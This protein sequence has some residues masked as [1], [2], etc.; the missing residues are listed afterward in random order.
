MEGGRVQLMDQCVSGR[1]PARLLLG[2]PAL[3]A[4]ALA[5]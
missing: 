1:A 4:S 3:E 5:S 2:M